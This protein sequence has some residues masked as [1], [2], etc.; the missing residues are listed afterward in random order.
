MLSRARD[1]TPRRA[2]ALPRA[3]AA[4]AAPPALEVPVASIDLGH[5]AQ[6][7]NHPMQSHRGPTPERPTPPPSFP[8]ACMYLPRWRAFTV[9]QLRMHPVTRCPPSLVPNR[10]HLQPPRCARSWPHPHPAC[11]RTHPPVLAPSQRTAP[12]PNP[13]H[14]LSHPASTARSAPAPI[15][16]ERFERMCSAGREGYEEMLCRTIS[17]LH[18]EGK[19]FRRHQKTRDI[20]T[21]KI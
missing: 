9:T 21:M 4:P 11:A 10:V 12:A 6:P 3:I 15:R 14:R 1:A 7:P 2:T 18:R 19:I 13:A 5:T 16:I 20:A 17:P 8:H